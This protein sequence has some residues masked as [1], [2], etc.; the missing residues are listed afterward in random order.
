MSINCQ[1]TSIFSD[2]KNK[3]ILIIHGD[4]PFN[5]IQEEFDFANQSFI[6][7]QEIAQNIEITAKEKINYLLFEESQSN[8]EKIFKFLNTKIITYQASLFSELTQKIDKIQLERSSNDLLQVK[9][10]Q[11]EVKWLL[12]KGRPSQ[13]NRQLLSDLNQRLRKD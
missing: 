11:K 10:L 4:S 9:A 13:E 1:I 5:T 2:I 7:L 6:A 3:E 12:K 8:L